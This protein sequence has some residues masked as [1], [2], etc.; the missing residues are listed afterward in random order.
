M[1]TNKFA[2]V[3]GANGMALA[4]SFAS[5]MNQIVLI[6]QC[7]ALGGAA[8]YTALQINKAWRR[9]KREMCLVELIRRSQVRCPEAAQGK[10]P[11]ADLLDAMDKEKE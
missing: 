5:T 9:R 6:L 10:C 8:V 2:Q 3:I 7:C 11:V 1:E 4:M